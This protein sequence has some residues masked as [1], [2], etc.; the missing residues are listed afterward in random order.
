MEFIDYYKVLGVHKTA[1][2]D[3]IKAAC[4]KLARQH[5][6]DLSPDDTEAKRSQNRR[7]AITLRPV[8]G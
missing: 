5:P 3:E 6:P 1:T 7:V 8:T 4:R 2:P